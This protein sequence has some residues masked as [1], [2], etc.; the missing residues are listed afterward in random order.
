MTDY[1]M[2]QHVGH[3]IVCVEYRQNAAWLL[4]LPERQV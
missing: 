2:F 3:K 1:R 4:G